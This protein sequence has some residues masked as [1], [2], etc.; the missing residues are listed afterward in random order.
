MNPASSMF[1]RE[2]PPTA[3][4]PAQWGDFLGPRDGTLESGLARF[5]GVPETQIE[6]SGMAAFVVA[7]ETLKR[8]SSRRSVVIPAYTCP[9]VLLAIQQAGLA[10]TLCDIQRDNFAFDADALRDCTGSDTL[11]VVPTHLAG[12]V[13]DLS[14]TLEIAKQAGAFVIEDAA[15]SLGATWRGEPAGT[16]GDIGLFSLSV[17]KGLTLFKG[18]FLVARDPDIRAALRETGEQI[19]PANTAAEIVRCVELLGYRAFYNPRGLHFTYGRNLRRWLARGH[20]E[21][22]VG[23]VF[24]GPIPIHRVSGFRKS[25]G[26]RALPRLRQWISESSARARTRIAMLETIPGIDIVRDLPESEGTW[27]FIMVLFREEKQCA[28]AL[29]RLWTAGLGVTKLFVRALPD[30]EFL[31]PGV[32]AASVPNARSVAA[33]HLTISNSP[34]LNDNDFARIFDV[35]SACARD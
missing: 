33:R 1:P 10:V 34:W 27:P 8:R 21:R 14:D 4:L 26:A 3:G 23:D 5:L 15:Q 12:I 13:S 35:V 24:E 18:G 25:A 22:A 29:A 30:Y 20:P 11:C 6:C 17:G 7:L 32:P 9:T 2:I 31:K 28:A 19:V 16:Y